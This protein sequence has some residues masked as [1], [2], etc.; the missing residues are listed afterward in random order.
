M[1]SEHTYFNSPTPCGV[2]HLVASMTIHIMAFQSTHPVRGGTGRRALCDLSAEISIHPPCAGW[3]LHVG[4]VSFGD[5][6]SIH[7]PRAGWDA[8]KSW[9]KESGSHFNPPTPCGVGLPHI[10]RR[11]P[12]IHF[13]PPPAGWDMRS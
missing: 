3:D 5:K 6:I 8:P 4:L 1:I 7:P 11:Q 2:G 9:T 13:N 12:D 10:L